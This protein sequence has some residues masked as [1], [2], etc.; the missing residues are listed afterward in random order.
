VK[1]LKVFCN[2]HRPIDPRDI[3]KK[4]HSTA[5][6]GGLGATAFES[7]DGALPL[8]PLSRVSS[9]VDKKHAIKRKN[10]KSGVRR[11]PE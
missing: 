4:W 5:I 7:G 10:T 3:P 6:D 2:R 1:Q 9:K 8:P 11:R